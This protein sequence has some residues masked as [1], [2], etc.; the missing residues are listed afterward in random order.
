MNKLIESM[1]EVY[2]YCKR[3]S[4]VLF[5]GSIRLSLSFYPAFFFIVN[6]KKKQIIKK[7]RE[8]RWYE[9]I[10]SRVLRILIKYYNRN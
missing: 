7:K 10:Y 3:T 5:N 9:Y 1:F 2:T 4:R 8:D 6:K